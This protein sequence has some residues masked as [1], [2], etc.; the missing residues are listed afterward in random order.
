MTHP[1]RS[2]AVVSILAACTLERDLVGGTTSQDVATS[3]TAATDDGTSVGSTSVDFP[4]PTACGITDTCACTSSPC[5]F[6]CQGILNG[7][8]SFTCDGDLDCRTECLAGACNTTCANGARCDLDCDGGNCID[9]CIDA[10]RCEGTCEGVGCQLE[11]E[12][13]ESCDVSCP[14]GGCHLT[15]TDA[16]VCRIRDCTQGCQL[17]CGGAATCDNSCGEATLCL[18]TP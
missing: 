8:C 15:C 18:T 17:T 12:G 11:C 3:T 14:G 7:G 1:S 2:L 6:A 16:S 9:E 13:T 5:A 4:V 10:E